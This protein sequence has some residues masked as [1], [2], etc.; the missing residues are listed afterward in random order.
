MTARQQIRVTNRGLDRRRASIDAT[1]APTTGQMLQAARHKKGVDLYRAERET[2]I[3]ARYLAALEQG[4]AH[5]L[6]S[7]VYTKGFLRNYATYL[8][9]DPEEVVARWKGETLAPRHARQVVAP[10]PRPLAAPRRSFTLTPGLF[11]AAAL[12]LVVLG[13]I[14]Y[15]VVQV[16]RFSQPPL[17]AVT[18][19]SGG[20]ITV[21]ADHYLLSGSASPGSS[22]RIG[23][24]SER[25]YDVTADTEG[26]W[27][28]DV[29][30]TR[31]Q[32]DFRVVASDP[33]TGKDSP[34]VP[35]II[36][37]PL[38]VQ[39]SGS[40]AQPDARSGGAVP[41]VSLSPV[42]LTVAAPTDGAA[43]ADG[44]VLVQGTTSGS[45][46]TIAAQAAHADPS[47]SLGPAA[48]VGASI[49]ASPGAGSVM[50]PAAPHTVVLV[51]GSFADTLVLPSGTWSVTITASG[52]DLAPTVVTRTVRVAFTGLTIVVQARS[53]SPWIKVWLDGAVAPG[54][55]NGKL[56]PIGAGATF[57]ATRTITVRTGYAAGTGYIINGVDRGILGPAANP[58]T[59][60]FRAGHEPLRTAS[61]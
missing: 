1:P 47:T 48:S 32:N 11:V 13:F 27:S 56:L 21:D 39:S 2:K 34:A 8:G 19:P 40:T 14:G 41:S 37:V 45:S 46:V 61:R 10:P 38:P 51:R 52:R 22:I 26:R 44:A 42:A 49:A 12:S 25:T 3:R 6:P 9:L 54:F 18:S 7:P 35:V 28:R 5:L 33:G 16:F 50:G 20:H 31:G 55:E 36:T 15:V 60:L 57:T 17:L 29:P 59:W 24:V 43:S 30:L 58:E 23:G 53:G 4:D